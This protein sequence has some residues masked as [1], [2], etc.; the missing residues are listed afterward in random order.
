MALPIN[1]CPALGDRAFWLKLLSSAACADR[2]YGTINYRGPSRP[3][4]AATWSEIPLFFI[5]PEEG[6]D[7][8]FKDRSNCVKFTVAASVASLLP[9]LADDFW[10]VGCASF[11]IAGG[12]IYLRTLPLSILRAPYVPRRIEPAT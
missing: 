12:Q 6:G 1:E 7:D 10:P 3:H 4:A 8:C 2:V 9:P 11:I 5:Q